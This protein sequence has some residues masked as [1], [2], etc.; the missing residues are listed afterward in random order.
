[1]KLPTMPLLKSLVAGSAL[2]LALPTASVFAQET[3]NAYELDEIEIRG[4]SHLPSSPP[5][6]D[7][8]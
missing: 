6:S 3:D 2:A 5:K 1:M 8:S 7:C 4:E